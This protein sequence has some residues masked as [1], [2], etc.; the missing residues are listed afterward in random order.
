MF[1]PLFPGLLGY[2]VVLVAK[3]RPMDAAKS[4]RD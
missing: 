2:Q 3:A 1:T 4:R